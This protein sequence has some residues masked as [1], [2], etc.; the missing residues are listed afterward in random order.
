MKKIAIIGAG[1]L[2]QLIAKNIVCTNETIAGYYDDFAQLGSQSTDYP[3]LGR[4]DS[5]LDDYNKG[6]FTHLVI[7]VGYKHMNFRANLFQKFRN[8]IPFHNVIHPSVYIDKT[9]TLGQGIVIFANCTI[10]FGSSIGDN[11]L[12]NTSVNISHDSMVGDHSFLGPCVAMAGFVTVGRKCFIG[13]NTTI[14]DN[15]TLCNQTQTGGGTV[16]IE[17]TEVS[18]LYV[19]N[20]ARRVE[21][22]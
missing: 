14:I 4:T 18:G 7:A 3:I 21:H 10:D 5:I 15:L 19:G 13:I 12:L 17:S 6:G 22:R 16:L 11:V 1:D 8:D 20:P 9:V 2:G